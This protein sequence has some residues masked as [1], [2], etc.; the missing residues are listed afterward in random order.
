MTI[1][2]IV[3]NYL[4]TALTVPVYMEVP[5]AT[6]ESLDGPPPTYVAIERTGGGE[7]NHID[8]ATLAIQSIGPTLYTAILLNDSVKKAMKEIVTLNEISKCTLNT[9]YNF[10]DTTTKQRRY[11]AIY[12]LVYLGG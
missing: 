5:A 4:K 11:Q 8:S 7:E 2:E 9:D 12:D 3:Y 10:S 6:P 1:E